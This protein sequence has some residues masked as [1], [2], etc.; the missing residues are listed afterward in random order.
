MG[1]TCG[2]WMEKYSYKNV[3]R[4]KNVP[5]QGVYL[6]DVEAEAEA[7]AE[8]PGSGLFQRKRKQKQ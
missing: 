3:P 2:H 8:A 5:P 7:E 4:G 1:D 6:S